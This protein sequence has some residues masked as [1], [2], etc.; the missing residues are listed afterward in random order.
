[1]SIRTDMTIEWN[2]SPRLITVLAPSTEL[3]IQ[4]LVD[5]CRDWEDSPEGLGHPNLISAAGKE[6][7][8]G[9]VYVGIT[10]TLLNANVAFEAR[11]EIIASGYVDANDS[12]GDMLVDSTA[13]FVSD[14]VESG[15]F[16]CNYTD[17]SMGTVIYVSANYLLHTVLEEGINNDWEIGDEYKIWNVVP[18]SITGGN[19]V[20][21]DVDGDSILPTFPTAFVQLRLSSSSSATLQ[22]IS[23]LQFSTF[24]NAVWIDAVNGTGGTTFPKGTAIE[25]V[26]NITD[27]QTIAEERGFTHLN[28]LGTGLTVNAG[29]DLTGYV[30]QGE[31]HDRTSLI[32]VSGAIVEGV[33]FNNV[34]LY[35]DF[36]GQICVVDRHSSVK[37]VNDF[38]ANV[39][40]SE[41]DG[42]IKLNLGNHRHWIRC[43]SNQ[44]TTF[45][46]LDFQGID[47]DLVL[48]GYTG[49]L[50][51]TNMTAGN[52]SLYLDSGEVELDSSCTGGTININGSG[53]LTDNS[54][55]TTVLA[56]NFVNPYIIAD[57]VLNEALSEHTTSGTIGQVIQEL[58]GTH[59]NKKVLTKISDTEYK[60]ELY[61][62]SGVVVIRTHRLTK[63]GS[64]ETR[65]DW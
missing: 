27:A 2:L 40:L 60:E 59:Y 14:G 65:E 45:P 12:T 41:L 7:L 53:K 21:V 54:A 43:T 16:V 15:A 3:T 29:E 58:R 18:C 55:G 31:Y 17:G 33:Q 50:R 37:N 62:D 61:D 5:T 49:N 46:V 24:Q 19:L 47:Q 35:G 63:S 10:A 20:A 38:D 6:P 32:V 48:T 39:Y 22:E 30:I 13:D 44:Q 34:S 42:T 25:P 36:N 9:S 56:S 57:Q 28:I 26:N 52:L 1:M 8:G 51:V 23:S 11:T 64:V 4:D